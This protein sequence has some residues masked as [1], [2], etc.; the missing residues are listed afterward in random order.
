ME[1][2]MPH[3]GEAVLIDKVLERSKKTCLCVAQVADGHPYEEDGQVAALVGLELIAQS[4]AACVG[5]DDL[6]EAKEPGRGF[7][8][9]VP[10]FELL[11]EHLPKDVPLHIRVT[12][13]WDD[14]PAGHFSGTVEGP[15]GLLVKGEVTV[16][17]APEDMQFPS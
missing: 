3:R 12:C 17:R 1:E 5:A 10:R 14:P 2:M 6:D 4:V 11:A 8:A 16:I 15:D 9:S 7:I 13:E